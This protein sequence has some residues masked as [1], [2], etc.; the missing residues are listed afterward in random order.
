MQRRTQGGRGLGE[1]LGSVKSIVPG[2]FEAQI[3]S[4]DNIITSL[5]NICNCV[6]LRTVYKSH[7]TTNLIFK[8]IG[9]ILENISILYMTTFFQQNYYYLKAR[10]G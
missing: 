6:C 10:L 1:P 5:F 4:W 2:V 9:S 7:N 8:F 3:E